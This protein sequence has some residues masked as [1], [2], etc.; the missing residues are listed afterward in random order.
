MPQSF[1][2]DSAAAL[3]ALRAMVTI[4]DSS[5]EHATGQLT[6]T[7]FRALRV[8]ADRTPV[9]MGR[10]ADELTMNPS[11][12]TRACDRLISLGLLQKAQNPLNKREILLAPTAKG[13]QVVERVDEERRRVLDA[14]LDQLAPEVRVAVVS[15]LGRFAEAADGAGTVASSK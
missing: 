13:R 15:A 2:S 9:T 6:L 5:V 4:A 1:S 11:T 7:Q 12:V 3:A 8:A 14:V 10:V